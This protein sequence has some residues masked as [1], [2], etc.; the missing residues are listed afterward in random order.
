MNNIDRLIYA[1]AY[2]NHMY[3]FYFLD[4]KVLLCDFHRDQAWE[5]WLRNSSNG[6]HLHRLQVLPKLRRIANAI[7][8]TEYKDAVKNLIES[9]EWKAENAAKF[10]NYISKTWLPIHAVIFVHNFKTDCFS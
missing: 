2:K 1:L 9:E 4:C 10:R 3:F 5:R 6:M 8:E 7:T